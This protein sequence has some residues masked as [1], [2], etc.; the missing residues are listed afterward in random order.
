M[1]DYHH[2][3]P[4]GNGPF[5]LPSQLLASSLLPMRMLL[6]AYSILEYVSWGMMNYYW[7]LLLLVL[8]EAFVTRTGWKLPQLARAEV[9]SRSMA[10]KPPTEALEHRER[11]QAAPAKAD[12]QIPV[13][14]QAEPKTMPAT[15]AERQSR[16]QR[17]KKR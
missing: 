11:L 7:Q 17:A 12:S 6:H 2:H 13:A 5:L 4:H 3:F 10:A 15:E 1:I 16:F 9:K 8:W 14:S